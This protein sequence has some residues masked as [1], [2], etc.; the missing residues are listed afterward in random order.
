VHRRLLNHIIAVL[1]K[2]GMGVFLTFVL[3]R[4]KIGRVLDFLLHRNKISNQSKTL[5][6]HV[7]Q[8]LKTKHQKLLKI[9]LMVV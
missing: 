2:D 5:Q 4:T 7:L 3:N 6:K 9:S 1:A 8:Q